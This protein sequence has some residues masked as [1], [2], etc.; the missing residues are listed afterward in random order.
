MKNPTWYQSA[1]KGFNGTTTYNYHAYG[2]AEY[3][4][5]FFYVKDKKSWKSHCQCITKHG[6][7]YH[8]GNI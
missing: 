8:A 4:E 5:F 2:A 7:T 6:G 3:K 1:E